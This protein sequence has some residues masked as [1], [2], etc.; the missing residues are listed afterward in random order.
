MLTSCPVCVCSTDVPVVPVV[1]DSMPLLLT[2]PLP[3]VV[4]IPEPLEPVE[5]MTSVLAVT[6]PAMY[7][8][9]P[10]STLT[11]ND[12]ALSLLSL[13]IMDEL[14]WWAVSDAP[15]VVLVSF[16]TCVF[17][18][19]VPSVPVVRVNPFRLLT[20]PLP[21]VVIVPEPLVGR[22]RV[23]PLSAFTVPVTIMLLPESRILMFN[24]PELS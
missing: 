14:I 20:S 22:E 6:V 7:M 23:T 4:I 11:F 21:T 12:P 19:D 2:T 9:Y 18:T 16:P 5:S 10:G 1:T 8:L 17:S 15:E 3:I 13:K 24:A